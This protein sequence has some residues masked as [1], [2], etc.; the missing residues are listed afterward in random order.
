MQSQMWGRMGGAQYVGLPAP[1]G[2]VL[3]YLPTDVRPGDKIS[4][5]AFAEP[6]GRSDDE[7]MQNARVLDGD[8]L[9]VG[10]QKVHVSN[11]TFTFTVP[12][13]TT[14][15]NFLLQEGSGRDI[16]KS[17]LP[18]SRSTAPV[19]GRIWVPAVAESGGTVSLAGPFD[20]DRSN[21]YVRVDGKEVGVLAESPRSCVFAAPFAMAGPARLM[22]HERDL[23][24]ERQINVVS[25][26][27]MAPARTIRSGSRTT[28][29]VQ[30]DGLQNVP[31]GAFPIVVELYND[32]PKVM[33]F[34]G[35]DGPVYHL[36]I[37]P[38][39]VSN[40]H[41]LKT[42]PIVGRGRGSFRVSYAIYSQ[43]TMD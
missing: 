6:A 13:D 4:G 25:L 32:N 37:T 11:T 24:V 14:T 21:T 22:V 34:V 3:I 17:D 20:G 36:Q 23:S 30:V 1:G 28:M 8:V 2:R 42:V 43:G 12:P 5:S 41:A 29:A 31:S 16:A 18:L 40:G 19:T 26:T 35:E 7:R 9:V 33:K 10:D 15:L 39:D 38:S 27:V